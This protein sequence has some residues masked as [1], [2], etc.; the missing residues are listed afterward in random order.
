MGLPYYIDVTFEVG[1]QYSNSMMSEKLI[2]HHHISKQ[3]SEASHCS[4][5]NAMGSPQYA[6]AMLEIVSKKTKSKKCMKIM[7][8]QLWGA[9]K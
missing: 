4:M 5:K 7:N 6:G 8:F 9:S 1:S 3:A 2:R